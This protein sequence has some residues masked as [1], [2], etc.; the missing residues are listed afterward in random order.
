MF[1]HR[2]SRCNS[3][4]RALQEMRAGDLNANR[5]SSAFDV[6]GWPLLGGPR[7]ARQATVAGVVLSWS[8]V[9]AIMAVNA[10]TAEE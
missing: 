9:K 3:E 4:Q 5:R 8:E 10:R 7:W 1:G 6:F 2:K